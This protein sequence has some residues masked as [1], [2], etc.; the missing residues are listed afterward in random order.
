MAICE[1]KECKSRAVYGVKQNF[2]TRCKDKEHIE[3]NMVYTPRMYCSHEKRHSK[4]EDCKNDLT[5]EVNG[6]ENKST[7]GMKQEFP[8]R[9]KIGD[10]REKRMVTQSR[11]YCHHYRLGCQCKTCDGS[12]ICIHGRHRKQC[13]ECH[14]ASI[15]LHDK[16]RTAC[17]ICNPES[18]FFCVRRYNNDTRC[19]TKKNKEYDNHCVSCFVELFP[20]DPKTEMVRLAR[21]ELN[22]F[23]YLIAEFPDKFIYG[24]QL[25]IT[26]REEKCTLFNRLIDF[27]TEFDD[28]VL[29]I[30]VDED[31]HKYY[32]PMDEKLRIMQIY[33]DAGK[34]LIFIR[35]NPDS[36][37]IDGKI[38]KTKMSKRREALKDKINEI[39]DKINRGDK[40]DEWYTE[41][42]LFFDEGEMKDDTSI[43]CSGISKR[44]KRRCRR[45]VAKEGMFCFRH[46]LH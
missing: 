12:S 8:S 27:Q 39:I 34:N 11:S 21:K 23:R 17:Y 16:R 22:I 15:C 37:K 31:Q 33:Q 43:R 4:C 45:K 29:A 41:I 44:A 35:F 38:K 3:K 28:C 24:K 6:C 25:L 40:F 19:I 20:N 42:K 5:C 26:D 36:Y 18:N 1:V 7:Y 9:C 32:D 30:E 14:G 13:K 46:I 2:A 10:H